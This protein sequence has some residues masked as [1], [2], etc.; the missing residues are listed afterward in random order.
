[1]KPNWLPPTYLPSHRQDQWGKQPPPHLPWEESPCHRGGGGGECL[2]IA[3]QETNAGHVGTTTLTTLLLARTGL[4]TIGKPSVTC[5]LVRDWKT[6]N[7]A[8]AECSGYLLLL[9]KPLHNAVFFPYHSVC[10]QSQ[11]DG[12]FLGSF[13]WLIVRDSCWCWNILGNSSCL[14]SGLDDWPAGNW[15]GHLFSMAFSTV[16]AWASSKHGGGSNQI[17]ILHV[18]VLMANFPRSLGENCKVSYDLALQVLEHD[19]CY[20]LWSYRWWSP[21]QIQG[22]EN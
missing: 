9:N 11:L 4:W 1:M 13:R 22:E 18:A 2:Q 7:F 17:L 5:M 6:R 3:K 15:L 21:S 19:F 10:W 16:V 8:L 14:A 12:S 20:I